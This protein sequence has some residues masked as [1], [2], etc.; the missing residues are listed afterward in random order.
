MQ[1]HKIEWSSTK[2]NT[3]AIKCDNFI[4]TIALI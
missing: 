4:N 2:V 3:V 1:I